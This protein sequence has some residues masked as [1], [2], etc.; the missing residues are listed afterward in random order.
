[1]YRIKVF[2][3]SKKLPPPI[4]LKV[5]RKNR[6]TCRITSE[7][8]TAVEIIHKRGFKL[9]FIDICGYGMEILEIIE[10][11][12]SLKSCILIVV[13]PKNRISNY[14]KLLNNGAFDI[15]QKPLKQHF[16]EASIKRAYDVIN[17]YRELK[18]ISSLNN[19]NRDSRVQVDVLEKEIEEL[20]IDELVKKKLSHLF[21]RHSNIKLTGLYSLGMPLVEKAFI[22]TALKAAKNNQVMASRI[23]GINRNTLKTKMTKL[24][25]NKQ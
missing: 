7:Q 18:A 10:R 14:K 9:V 23:L 20:G 5:L 17:L 2:I 21:S 6:L 16:V 1:M 8:K 19:S 11:I 15:L 13:I 25:I 4:L 12:S 3:L 22:E 24:S